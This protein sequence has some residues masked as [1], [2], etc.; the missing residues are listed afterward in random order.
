MDRREDRRQVARSYLRAEQAVHDD[1][2]CDHE[3]QDLQ[4]WPE[5]T[6][7]QQGPEERLAEKIHVG[8]PVNRPG[9]RR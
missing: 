3:Q 7:A 1:A 6:P 8:L 9:A 5:P 4:G 2:R